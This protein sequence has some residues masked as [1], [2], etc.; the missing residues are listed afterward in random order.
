MPTLFEHPKVH[1]LTHG[2]NLGDKDAS[3]V[4]RRVVTAASKHEADTLLVWTLLKVDMDD[5]VLQVLDGV[6]QGLR[7][8]RGVELI[9]M[10]CDMNK[11]TK[12]FL[13]WIYEQSPFHFL[14]PVSHTSQSTFPS[15]ADL[16]LRVIF[17]ENLHVFAK[18]EESIVIFLL[19]D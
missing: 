13:L 10:G 8:Q 4:A 15:S 3:G 14:K 11:W 1:R 17:Q 19:K 7:E 5:V 2:F 9:E 12:D 16:H 18:I 6:K